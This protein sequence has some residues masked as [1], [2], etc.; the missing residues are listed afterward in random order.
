MGNRSSTVIAVDTQALREVKDS[1]AV[2]SRL[3]QLINADQPD[4]TPLTLNTLKARLHS[5]IVDPLQ[6]A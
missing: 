5:N 4:K 6:P 1:D 2:L 3:A